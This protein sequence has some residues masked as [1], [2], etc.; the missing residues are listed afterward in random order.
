MQTLS[1]VVSL[2]TQ[3]PFLTSEQPGYNGTQTQRTR[4]AWLVLRPNIDLSS[5]PIPGRHF[6]PGSL[7]VCPLF[8]KMDI[9]FLGAAISS[10][11]EEHARPW[12][13]EPYGMR[14]STPARVSSACS[15]K[16]D[17]GPLSAWGHGKM[18]KHSVSCRGAH[19]DRVPRTGHQGCLG[20]ADSTPDK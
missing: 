19:C 12:N 13:A 7:P 9:S 11:K 17:H 16:L 14:L 3:R 8:Y 6:T 20:A 10:C 1:C 18:G 5:S 15:M 2:K 4:L